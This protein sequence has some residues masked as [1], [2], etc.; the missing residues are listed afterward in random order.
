MVDRFTGE[1]GFLDA[2]DFELPGDADGDNVYELVV[3]VHDGELESMQTIFV[4]VDDVSGTLSFQQTTFTGGETQVYVGFVRATGSGPD[5]PT[6][7]ISGGADAALFILNPE[8]GYLRF[9]AVPDYEAPADAD[10]DGV[11]EVEVSAQAGEAVGTATMVVGVVGVNEAPVLTGPDRFTVAEN[12]T[13]VATLEVTDPEQG[14]LYFTIAGGV[15]A[16]RF[17]INSSTGALAFRTAPNFETPTDS[18]QD[19][20]YQVIVRVSDGNLNSSRM[21][22]VMVDNVDEAPVIISGGGASA[23][24]YNVAE[25]TVS[26]A[27]I[28]ASDPDGGPVTFSIASGADAARFTIDAATGA[29]SFITAP[30][31]EAPT[32]ANFDNRYVV[33]VRA[34]EGALADTQTVTVAVAN[35]SGGGGTFT[36]TSAADTLTGGEGSDTINGLGGNDTLVG[37]DGSDRL[38][39]GSGA[40]LLTGGSGDDDFIFTLPGDSGPGASDRILDFSRAQ[41][42]KIDLSAIDARTT[43]SGNQAFTFIGTSAFNGSSGGSGG[44]GGPLGSAGQLRYFQQGS[45]TIVQGDVNGDRVADFQF[46]IDQPMSLTSSDFIL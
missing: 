22:A 3:G 7:T 40:D 34:G 14:W 12:G 23:V 20:V 36:G 45:D 37:G 11:Y 17:S 25:N 2:P 46:I 18:N 15:D 31:Y 1:F 33:V 13:Q 39:G 8:N 41:G 5:A 38:T 6:Y 21:F 32:D 9:A 28:A 27:T 43:Q 24:T 42:D 35:V 16:G 30:D 4:V 29:L 19:N 44:S 10:G 26:V